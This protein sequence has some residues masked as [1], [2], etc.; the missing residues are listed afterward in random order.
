VKKKG[1]FD[2]VASAPRRRRVRLIV[3]GVLAALLAVGAVYLVWFS[4]VFTVTA[5][6]VVGVEGIPAEQVL[7]SAAIAT[8]VPLARVDTDS[9]SARVHQL[10]WVAEAEQAGP[11]GRGGQREPAARHKQAQGGRHVDGG[12]LSG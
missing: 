7:Q 4:S 11:C 2:A 10:G 6:K 9:A 12:R 1:A 5:V 8:G 3:I